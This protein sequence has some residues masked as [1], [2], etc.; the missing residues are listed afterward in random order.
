MEI[1]GFK[2]L[3]HWYKGNLH[4]HTTNSDGKLTPWE[5]AELYKRNGYHFLCFS[6][7]D[8]FTDYRSLFDAE[9]F[10]ILPGLEASAALCEAKGTGR[11][12]KVHHIH[13]ILGTEAMQKEA[14][15]RGTLFSHM[16]MF[17]SELYYGEWDGQAAAD[18]LSDELRGRGCFTTYNHPVWSRVREDEFLNTKGIWA[19]EIY[20]YNTVNESGTGYDTLHWDEMLRAGKRVFGFASDDNHNEGLFDDSCGGYV[21]VNAD[22]LSHEEIVNNLLIG[23]Y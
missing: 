23:N 3:K 8:K 14:R 21:M 22:C 5:A 13:G 20:N 18:R 7:H 4:S 6:E 19:V 17:P 1:R 16:E 15:A 11:K 9:D 2:H 10:L 12:K